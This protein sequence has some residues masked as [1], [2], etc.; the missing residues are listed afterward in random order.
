MST[1]FDPQALLTQPLMA[2]LA[3]LGADGPRVTPVWFLS[4]GDVVWM[5]GARDGSSTQRLQADPRCAVDITR[6]APD[7]GIL[8]HLGLRGKA[9]VRPMDAAL[10]R[11]LL[12]KYLGADQA[13][14]NPWFIDRIARIDDPDGR[15]I[16]LAPSSTFTNNVS[17]FKTGPA[18]AWP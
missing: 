17:Y 9:T 18:L 1:P 10:F 11:R 7:T 12:Q 2:S 8:L 13:A 6:F 3:T 4:E 14:W 15:L 5:L 16:R